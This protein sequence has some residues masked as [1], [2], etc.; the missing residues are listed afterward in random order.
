MRR[1]LLGV[2]VGVVLAQ[3]APAAVV[4]VANF[5]PGEI[6]FTVGGSDRKGQTVTLAPAQVAPVTVSG[7]ADITFPTRPANVTL[8]LDPY[9]AYVFLPDEKAGRRLEGIELPDAPPERD[10]RPELNPAPREPVKI[11]ITLL[12]DDVDPRTDRLWQEAIRTRFEEAA[13]VVEAHSGVRFV[14]A[15]FETWE[16]DPTIKD[17]RGLLTDFEGRVKVKPGQLAVG[18]TSRKVE[19]REKDAASFG[20][21]R[22]FPTTHVLIREWVPKAE[23]DKVEV[24]IHHLGLAL[25]ATLSPDPGSVMRPKVAD[26]LA[27]IPQYR[28]R[29]DPLNTLV[30]NLWA[31]E[32]RRGPVANVADVAA[33]NRTRL[34]RVYKALQKVRPG[35]PLAIAYLAELDREIVKN[36]DPKKD[37]GVVNPKAPEPGAKAARSPRDDVARAVVRAVAERARANTGPGAIT[38]DDLTAAYVK[39]A[40]SAA[41]GVDGLPAD[42]PD[43]TAGFLLGLAVALDDS[44]G[45]RSDALTAEAVKGA[46]SDADREERL[47]VLGNPTI[48]GRRDLCRRF[49]IGCGAGELLTPTRAEELAVNRSLSLVGTQRQAGLSFPGLAAELAGVAFAGAARETPDILRRAAA[50]FTLADCLPETGGLRDGLSVE[51]FEDDYS[52]AGDD[53]FGAVLTDIRGRVKKVPAFNR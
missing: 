47:P 26:G 43:R 46:E 12:V 44:D 34:A 9:N 4:V 7:P 20:A 27:R 24:L 36:P 35:D 33:A 1:Y 39:A 19:D 52:D 37:P 25:G 3:P 49:V 32:L 13:A 41:L 22:A 21:T 29:F 50:K 15:G 6:T 28:F 53:R 5:T 11:P 45:L 17:L 14:F 23:P 38:G 30:M 18:Y 51:R 42:S 40:A 2:V 16:S 10:A 8:R 48:R 31:D